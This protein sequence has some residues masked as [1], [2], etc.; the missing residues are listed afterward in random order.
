MFSFLVE[1]KVCVNHFPLLVRVSTVHN[2]TYF[3]LG[4]WG[5]C[6][7]GGMGGKLSEFGEWG[8]Q[9]DN[10]V[11]SLF[12]YILSPMIWDAPGKRK[13]LQLDWVSI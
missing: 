11:I 12:F 9:P 3:S 7:M 2:S 8:I 13:I 5:V 4:R 10:K 1:K 6:R